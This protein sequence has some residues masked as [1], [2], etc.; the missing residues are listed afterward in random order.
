MMTSLH[1]CFL[2]SLLGRLNGLK[3]EALRS[4]RPETHPL[5]AQDAAP[6]YISSCP[7]RDSEP[8][9]SPLL[10][11][12]V[13]TRDPPGPSGPRQAPWWTKPVLSRETISLKPN[14]SEQ[15]VTSRAACVDRLAPLRGEGLGACRMARHEVLILC[16]TNQTPPIPLLQVRSPDE[17]TAKI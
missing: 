3:H 6:S 1:A 13:Y 17:M 14:E 11:A 8:P 7:G 12:D 16:R 2:K 10:A 15:L 4:K 5:F 9:N